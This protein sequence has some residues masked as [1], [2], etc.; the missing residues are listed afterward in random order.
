MTYNVLGG[1]LNLSQ[2]FGCAR[3]NGVLHTLQRYF[4]QSDKCVS[5]CVGG[6]GDI[7]EAARVPL[8]SVPLH[9]FEPEIRSDQSLRSDHS[10][11]L[12]MEQMVT[13]EPAMDQQHTQSPLMPA[14]HPAPDD[15]AM[16]QCMFYAVCNIHDR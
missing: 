14:D 3:G 9:P 16:D 4:L 8:P 2:Q 6:S 12:G 10:V 1:T 7:S 15:E 13:E 5:C 11:R